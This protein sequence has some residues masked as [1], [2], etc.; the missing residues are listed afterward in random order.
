MHTIANTARTGFPGGRS[1][2]ELGNGSIAYSIIIVFTILVVIVWRPST[3]A[4]FFGRR[5]ILVQI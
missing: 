3:L 4:N 2:Y 1:G 5:S